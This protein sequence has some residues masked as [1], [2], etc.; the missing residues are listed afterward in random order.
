MHGNSCFFSQLDGRRKVYS[1]ITR[2]PLRLLGETQVDI[3]PAG[4]RNQLAQS[5]TWIFQ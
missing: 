3:E 2:Q 5:I 1:R 4:D